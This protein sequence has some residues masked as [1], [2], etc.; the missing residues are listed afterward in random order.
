MQRL[1]TELQTHPLSWAFNQAVNKNETPDYYDVIKQP[2]G[3]SCLLFS[4][5]TE[6]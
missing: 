6:D 3:L 2:M 5:K 1:L 4:F